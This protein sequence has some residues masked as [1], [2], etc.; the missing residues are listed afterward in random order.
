MIRRRR[1]ADRAQIVRIGDREFLTRGLDQS[2]WTDA[3]HNSMS[4]SWPVFFGSFG[5]YFLAHRQC[6]TRLDCRPVF[7]FHRD[8]GD[9]RLWRYA[10]AKRLWPFGR[11]A[12]NLYRHVD[13]GGFHRP[14]F[15]ALL[16]AA[17]AGH[18]RRRRDHG[19]A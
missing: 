6:A 1:N 12:G 9:G 8:A 5:L 16:P 3:F 14:H 2:F 19:A 17:R 10:S 11:Y 13:P 15:R 18:F 7:L 4:V